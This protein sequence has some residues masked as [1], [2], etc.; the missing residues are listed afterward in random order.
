MSSSS[1]RFK[2]VVLGDGGVGKTAF[3]KRHRTGEFEKRYIATMGVE[4]NPQPVH[5][6][7][8]VR[9]LNTWDTAGQERFSGL[10]EGYVIGAQAAIIMCDLTSSITFKSIPYYLEM[11]RKECGD[12]PIVLCGNKVDCKE[13]RLTPKVITAFLESTRVK[14]PGLRF[15]YYDVSAKSNYNFEKPF[16]YLLRQLLGDETLTMVEAPPVLP[17]EVSVDVARLSVQVPENRESIALVVPVGIAPR[18][19]PA[20]APPRLSLADSVPPLTRARAPRPERMAPYFVVPFHLPG[21]HWEPHS[22]GFPVRGMRMTK[23]RAYYWHLCEHKVTL[24]IHEVAPNEPLILELEWAYSEYSPQETATLDL[25]GKFD[26][27]VDVGALQTAL[28]SMQ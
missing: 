4:V 18:G 12:V 15:Q 20:V 8:G 28:R 16:L 9:V 5:T 24:D 21:V 7:R 2:V 17:P 3:L 26:Y 25:S 6:S 23:H 22:S 13:R 27:P 1:Q 11:V 19:A 10:G 14:Y